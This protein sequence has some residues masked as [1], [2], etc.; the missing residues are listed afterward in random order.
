M[1]KWG[2]VMY[3]ILQIGI[4]L[5]HGNILKFK[6]VIFYKFFKMVYFEIKFKYVKN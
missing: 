5:F 3:L 4:D 1:A 2:Y 6:K